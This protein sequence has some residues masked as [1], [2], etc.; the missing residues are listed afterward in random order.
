M[1]ATKEF[2]LFNIGDE[3]FPVDLSGFLNVTTY[4]SDISSEDSVKERLEKG[5]PLIVMSKPYLVGHRCWFDD[6]YFINV[7][8]K[9]SDEIYSI[10]NSKTN[11]FKSYYDYISFITDCE[12]CAAFGY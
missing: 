9:N 11:V 4:E 12:E 10:M 7:K 5:E 2:K 8:F 6:E 3:I 1:Q